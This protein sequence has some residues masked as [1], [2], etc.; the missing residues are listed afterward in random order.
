[1][2]KDEITKEINKLPKEDIEEVYNFCR[3]L[4]DALDTDEREGE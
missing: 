1:M 3:D 2:E 4:L